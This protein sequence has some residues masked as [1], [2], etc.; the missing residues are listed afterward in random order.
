MN[1]PG[2]G[3]VSTRLAARLAMGG[4]A[5]V[6]LVSVGCAGAGR[7]RFP[8]LPM[9]AGAL[10]ARRPPLQAFRAEVK[11]RV[12]SAG[13]KGRFRAGL[14]ALPPD[15][16]LDVFHPLSGATL[17]SLGV[18]EGRLAA[19]WPSRDECLAA[20]ATTGLMEQLVGLPIPPEDLLPLLSGHVYG[21]AGVE[22]L[23][24]R[25]PPMEVSAGAGPAPAALDRLMVQ[26]ADLTTGVTWEAELLSA[27]QGMALRGRRVDRAGVDLE[28]E[29]PEWREPLAAGTAGF[30]A[31]VKLNVPA[32]SLRLDLEMRD[33][34]EGGPPRESLLPALPPG[35]RMVTPDML[36][37]LLPLG[38][39]PDAGGQH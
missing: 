9:E 27:R 1:G 16:R 38:A 30:P 33:W 13:E 26:A 17:M 19:V 11:G 7:A 28:V 29:Y 10:A 5:A 18:S 12:R 14:G 22:I 34:A 35:C 23:S 4:L 8:V 24:L 37:G 36:P 3:A 25:H 20:D 6:L 21:D 15:F 32:R 31:R 39:V 2:A